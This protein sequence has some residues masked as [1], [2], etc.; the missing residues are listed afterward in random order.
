LVD[1]L[2]IMLVEVNWF[3]VVDGYLIGWV[4]GEVVDCVGKVVVLCWFVE[5][6]GFLLSCTIV[7]GDG[8]NDF[9]MLDV[10][11]LGIVFNVKL[12]VCQ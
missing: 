3:E 12:V 10:V 4:V 9:D 8:V 1:E 2:G 7:I 6:E 5:F 11:G